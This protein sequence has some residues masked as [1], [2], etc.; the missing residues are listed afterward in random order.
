MSARSVT[1][2]AK[3]ACVVTVGF[4]S[5]V[6]PA[7]KGMELVALLQHAVTC[8]REFMGTRDIYT[9]GDQ[10][11]VDLSLVKPDQLVF[12]QGAAT[13]AATTGPLRL[14]GK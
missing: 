14:R 4:Q 3:Q 11:R 12:P 6:L 9:V 1:T 10:P 8:E 5:Y 2:P 7:N 13:P